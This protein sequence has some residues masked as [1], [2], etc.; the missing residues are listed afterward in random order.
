[1]L[2]LYAAL[3]EKERRLTAERTKA[4]LTARKAR[5]ARLGNRTKAPNA[6]ALGRRV[7][8]SD[9]DQCAA[10]ML[11]LVGSMQ[12][13]GVTSPRHRRGALPPRHLLASI[14]S[15]PRAI[16]A[17]RLTR[18]DQTAQ[19]MLEILCAFRRPIAIRVANR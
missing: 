7:Q 10:D 6:A 1:M 12:A 19:N 17:S 11:P 15:D 2:H 13:A 14:S 9:V 18:F 16:A 4:A 8:V 3:A 5:G